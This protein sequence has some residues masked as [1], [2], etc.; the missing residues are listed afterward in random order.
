MIPD[1]RLPLFARQLGTFDPNRA[2]RIHRPARTKAAE[3]IRACIRRIGQ[4]LQHPPMR[5]PSP[6]NL[7]C[8]NSAVCTGWKATSCE[9]RHHG[10][11]RSFRFEAGEHV[12]DRGAHLFVKIDHRA[13]ILVINVA[14]R[15][16]ETQFA[17]LCSSELGALQAA[18]E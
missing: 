14:D 9:R 13:P 1:Q 4:Q 10:V 3:Y 6:A 15:Q 5:Q 16:R 12:G 17:S 18:R 8:P 11:G 7:T 2:V